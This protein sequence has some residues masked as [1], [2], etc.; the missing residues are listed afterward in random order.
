M[1]TTTKHDL[2]HRRILASAGSGKTYQLT[3]RYLAL[4]SA[5]ADPGTILGSTFTRLAAGQIRNRILLRLVDAIND[6]AAH[7]ALAT[8]LGEPDLSADHILF[9]LTS[10]AR[11]VHRMNLRTLDSFF[12]S[13]VKAYSLEL[14]IPPGARMIDED[15]AHSLR[16]EAM[17][18]LLDEREPQKLITLLRL[19]TQ[20]ASNRSIMTAIDT[21]VSGLYEQFREAEPEA[22]DCI[23][24]LPMNTEPQVADFIRQLEE[25]EL[26]DKKSLQKAR[27]ED[28]Q[29]L[30]ERDWEPFLAKG[31]ATKVAQGETTY[32]R[33][34]IPPHVIDIYEPLVK[35]ARAVVV[36]L[37]R[38]QTLATRELL[39]L[40]DEQYSA[41]KRREQVMTFADL[42]YAM[43][44][45]ESLGTLDDI[46]YRIDAS[47][48]HL[49]LDEFQDTSVTQWRALEPFIN[50][51][52]AN[53]PPDHTFFCVGDVKQS[54]YGWRD[55]A[56][57]VL[58]KMP[59]LLAAADDRSIAAETLE[60]S[61]RSA[62][63]VIE[64]V[65]DVFLSLPGNLALEDHPR[66]REIW[67]NWFRR[68]S[69]A[70]DIPGYTELRLVQQA[71]AGENQTHLRLEAAAAL[72]AD[73]HHR[74]PGQSIAV[75]TRTNKSVA[76]LLFYLHEKNVPASGRGGG[77]LTDTPPV[78]VMLDLLRLA[79]H[80]N[81]TVAAFNVAG[82]PLAA[83]LG[84]NLSMALKGGLESRHRLA[85]RVRRSLM[86]DGYARTINRWVRDVA[87]SCDDRQL[88]R[89]LQL[90]E[91]A[92]QFDARPS[93]RP[94]DFVRMVEA[95]NVAEIRPAPVQVMN[96]HQSK[97]LEYD[98]VVLPDLDSLLT[99]GGT[100]DVVFERR[101][102]TGPITRICRYMSQNV[103][104][105][106]PE[107]APLFEHD[108]LR[109]V[110]ESLCVLY[111]AMTRARQGLYMLI[112]PPR[113]NEKTI[114]KTTASVLRC[115]L[116]GDDLEPGT[117]VYTQGDADWI[118]KSKAP[119]SKS[120]IT[121]KASLDRIELLDA[122]GR[123][124]PGVSAPAASTHDEST[125]GELLRFRDHEALE[126][127]TVIHGLFEQI[128]WLEDFNPDPR[129]L[130]QVARRLAPSADDDWARRQVD[131]FLKALEAPAVRELL[132]RGDRDETSLRVWREM[133]YARIVDDRVQQG[134]IDRL[135]TQLDADGRVIRATVID[136]KTDTVDPA[137]TKAC[138]ERYRPQLE[139]YRESATLRFGLELDA[140]GM[141][142]L[143][144]GPG[145]VEHLD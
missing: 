92:E 105:L 69:T 117:V 122:P 7:Q 50:E 76:R 107:L 1:T 91:Q 37:Y 28:L 55:A 64:T 46:C 133:P 113:D 121:P 112:N 2:A 94:G 93:L 97:G 87:A 75:L 33:T 102:A 81:D 24:R 130:L 54:I 31:I 13:I 141:L 17:R 96:V 51:I 106:V 111:V 126:R 25:C 26:P 99:G 138:A 34:P 132:S 114:P 88:R 38:E 145:R 43:L 134:R 56:P 52:V 67:G 49:L 109:T 85:D 53:S 23:P 90:L 66:V 61:W 73:L 123:I 140:V 12:A 42:K 6:S 86:E 36:N 139:S 110:R 83:T 18:R 142:I 144:T 41:L 143:F 119:P 16:T 131:A 108:R 27:R 71:E 62:S 30:Y 84:V 89:L 35:H 48:R 120:G 45:A 78:N 124:R 40:F 129:T 72:V 60:T 104:T 10:L 98:M 116:G 32:S 4:V 70:L 47:I 82:S 11:N 79:D 103:Q 3:N 8:A 137:E 22:W 20:N 15:E 9:M 101:G 125:L 95:I 100:P 74:A 44:R 29:R 39:T 136:F 5:G 135:E 21:A 63:S 14:G 58:E 128:H 115:A 118:E 19:I 59:E 57:D 77:P 127:G 65:N 80:P 68:H